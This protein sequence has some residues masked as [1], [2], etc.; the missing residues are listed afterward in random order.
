MNAQQ[1]Y[2]EATLENGSL[3]MIPHCACGN[4][5]NNDYFCETCNRRC[6]CYQIVCDNEATLELVQKYIRTSPQFTVY[7]AIL[8]SDAAE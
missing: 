7:T 1:D 4:A 5:L 3:V 2:N 8:A 6:H